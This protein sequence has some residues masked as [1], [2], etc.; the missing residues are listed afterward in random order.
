MR[1]AANIHVNR[2]DRNIAIQDRN[3][4]IDDR[5][6]DISDRDVD[7]MYRNIDAILLLSTIMALHNSMQPCISRMRKSLRADTDNVE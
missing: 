7:I 5:Y 4:N 2:S 1:A 3:V 6:M